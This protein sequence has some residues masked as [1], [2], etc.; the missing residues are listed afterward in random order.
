[1]EDGQRL[2]K[3]R[4]CRIANLH[5]CSITYFRGKTSYTDIVKIWRSQKI[6]L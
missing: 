4:K 6:Q 5:I 2:N 1:M 3:S